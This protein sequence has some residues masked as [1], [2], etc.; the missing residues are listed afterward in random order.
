MIETNP[1]TLEIAARLDAERKDGTMRTKIHG[2]PFVVKDNMATKDQMETMAGSGVLMGTVVLADAR[3]VALLRAAAGVLLG[4]ANRSEWASMRAS[5]TA[6]AYSS[7]GGQN[8]NPYILAHHPGGLSSGSAGVLASNM[9]AFSIGTETD[10]SVMFPAD[11]NALVGIKLTVGLTSNLGVI[12]ES[13][14]VDTVGTFGRCVE[15]ATI[16]LDITAERQADCE[17]HANHVELV[18]KRS[19]SSQ[20]YTA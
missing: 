16:I 6:E 15:D 17:S 1:D 3:V 18:P 4:K 13:P 8:R 19:R 12:P 2:I 20:L 10:G 5:Y 11:R 7:R 9:R 14:S